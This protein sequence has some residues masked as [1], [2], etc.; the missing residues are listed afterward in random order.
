LPDVRLVDPRAPGPA[1]AKRPATNH[2][3]A[4]TGRVYDRRYRAALGQ[5]VGNG[6]S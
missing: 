4:V 2:A 3:V 5:G 1:D 6:V